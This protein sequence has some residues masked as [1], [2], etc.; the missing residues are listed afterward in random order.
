RIASSEVVLAMI[1]E[2]W[3]DAA[4][5]AGNRRLDDPNDFVRLELANAL[6]TGT[7]IIPVLL[8]SAQMP[9]E[10]D[11]PDPLKSLARCNAQFIRGQAFKRDAEHLG[12]FI[13][14]FLKASSKPMQVA[15]QPVQRQANSPVRQALFGAYD[16]YVASASVGSFITVDD[17]T[18][19][20]IQ[21]AAD[22]TNQQTG[23]LNFPIQDGLSDA[24]HAAARRLLIGSLDG[25]SESDLDD[26]DGAIMM[27]APMDAAYLTRITMDIFEHVLGGLPDVPFTTRVEV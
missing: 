27:E 10:G 22:D 13:H 19:A 6:A 11:L 24:Q 23:C 18:D 25:G 21:F 8:E 1:G 20:C 7:R 12:A 17:G 9:S 4:D 2:T 26:I 16:S 5:G 3:L 15:P 14:D